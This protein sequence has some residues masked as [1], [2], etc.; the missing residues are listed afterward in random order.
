MDDATKRLTSDE[1]GELALTRAQHPAPHLTHLPGREDPSARPGTPTAPPRRPHRFPALASAALG[2]ILALTAL[3][4]PA[5]AQAPA[6]VSDVVVVPVPRSTN[7]LTVFWSAPDNAGKPAITGYDV[8]H[9]EAD[10]NNWTTVR[11]DAPNTSVIITGLSTNAYYDVQVRALNTGSGPWSST[12]EGATSPRP[13]TL[14]ANN[15]LI[16]D[17]LEVG[18]SFRLLYITGTADNVLG[19]MPLTAA[20]GT[21]I[22]DY[23]NLVLDPALHIVERGNFLNR[24]GEAFLRQTALLS[25]P[26][27]DARLITDTTWTETDRGVPI[28]WLNG[29]RVADDY[30]DFYDGTWENEANPRDGL[31]NPYPLDG[32][33]PWTGTD[34]DGTELFDGAASRAMGQATV[35]VGGLG[36]SAVGAGPLNGRVAFARTEERPLYGLW[37]VMVVGA[38]RRLVDNSHVKRPSSEEGADT[39]AAVRAQFFTTG[40]DSYGYSI[41]EIKLYGTDDDDFLG[42]VALYTTDEDG[43]PDL[44]DGLHATLILENNYGSPWKLTAPEGTVLK[45]TT[46]YAL[47]F[48]GESGSYPD[49]WTIAPDGEA[50]PAEGW[51]LADAL[52]YRSGTSWVENPDGRSLQLQIVGPRLVDLDPVVSIGSLII[53]EGIGTAVLPVTLSWPSRVSVSVP[54][55]S[56]GLTAVSPDDYIDG[57]GVL[58]FAPGE[59][60]AT[61]S[62]PIVDDAIPEDVESFGVFLGA[63]AGYRL[64]G[65]HGSNAVFDILDN[66]SGGGT[67]PPDDGG[68]GTEPPDDGDGGTEPPREDDGG[69]GGGGG[70]GAPPPRPTVNTDPVITTPGPFDVEENQ[71]RVVRIEALDS[72]PGDAIRSYAIAGGADGARFS[73]IPHT[74]VLSFREP[75]NFE[76][77]T[78]G[79]STDPPSKAGDNEYIVVVRVASGPVARD[80]TVEQAFAVRVIDDNGES[81]GAPDAPRVT[82]ALDTSLTVGW[83]EPENPGPPITDYDV[84]YR[85]GTSGFFINA[86]HEGTGR[87]A[88]LTGLEPATLH[89]V[90]VRAR[91]EEGTGRWSEPGEGRTLADPPAVLPFSVPDGG[92]ISLIA[93]STSP[94]LHVGYGQVETDDGM[95]PPAGLAIFSSRVN[96]VLV[97]EAGVPAVPPVLEGRIFAETDGAVRAGLAMANPNDTA[98][99]IAFFFTDSDGIDSGHDTFTLGPREQTARFLDEAPFN[100]GSAMFGTFTFTTDLPVAVIALRGFVNERSEFLMTTLPVAPIAVPTTGTV[101]FPHFAD[102]GGWTTQVILVNPTHAPIR[103]N[104]QFFDSGSETAPAAPK[105]LTLADGRSGSEFTYAIP[106]RS[107]TRLRTSNPTGP[108]DVGS[109]R[110]VPDTGQTAPSGVSIFTYQKDGM[111]VSEAGVLASTAGAA[112]RVYVETTATADE[113]SARLHTG[114]ASETRTVLRSGIAVT[115]TSDAPTTVRLELTDL[116]GTAT[117]PT[118]SL[119][120]PASGHVPR[121]IDEFF[122]TLTNPFSGLLRITST[123][124]NIAVVGLRLAFNQRGD[125]VTTTTPPV[126][127]N[128]IPP[129]SG[130]FFPHIAAGGSWATQFILFS[131]YPGQTATGMIRFRGQDGQL[132]ELS[133]APTTPPPSP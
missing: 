111:T 13:E 34:H 1:R 81:P 29:A 38:N 119:T 98:A 53:P 40:P 12:A 125:I 60:E 118:A 91:N 41:A 104:V 124:P 80:R 107:A 68:G 94:E 103:G 57:R 95:G 113:A 129:A 126:D 25:L 92:G 14:F 39:R 24:W 76:A 63:G 102:G 37:H 49:L 100:G 71:T 108:L 69:G 26:G 128:A 23:T 33:A 87:T 32:P 64:E 15:P 62:I 116:D 130:L 55:S 115:N 83:A 77:P 84:Q 58:A 66:D 72:D 27:A 2:C 31:G 9:S 78:D 43:D 16:P 99:T 61:I 114:I 105:T 22:H 36:S 56:G 90:Q 132:L 67:L 122:P 117:G 10:N 30:A 45:P 3:A 75:P 18:D 85:E 8:R 74:G 35:G 106:P 6:A 86:P 112:F 19:L 4:T 101:Y 11:Q 89:Q 46:T 110:A 20:T 93:Q 96:G 28:Y 44:E 121:F 51:S 120:L 5:L 59:T 50:H 97:S 109:V 21:G 131:R 82:L 47:V 70:G 133:V 52:L 17:D 88:T 7:S 65:N 79:V 73:I 48:L 54:W 42:P 127:E 123:A